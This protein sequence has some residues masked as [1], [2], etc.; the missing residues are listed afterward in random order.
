[1]VVHSIRGYGDHEEFA[2]KAAKV[3]EE[4]INRDAFRAF[5]LA[6]EYKKKRGLEPQQIMEVLFRAHENYGRNGPT[7]TDGVVDLR[8]RTMTLEEDGERWMRNCRPGSSAGT[9]GKDG[10]PEG[11][12]ITCSE[13]IEEWARTD[14]VASLA[15]H[16]MHEY[17]HLLGF[18]HRGLCKR[19]SLVYKLG[20]AVENWAR[21]RPTAG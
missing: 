16:M 21:Q 8:L 3:L 1:M 4:V 12:M 9:I 11:V 7:G 6:G 13:R 14:D 18:S 20:Y 15:G 10:G 5:I 2:R 17:L 19:K